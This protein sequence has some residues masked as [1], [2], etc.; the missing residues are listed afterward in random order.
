MTFNGRLLKLGTNDEMPTMDFVPTKT[1]KLAIE[2]ANDNFLSLPS[3]GNET[4]NGPAP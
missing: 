1:G 3:A 4:C 2:P